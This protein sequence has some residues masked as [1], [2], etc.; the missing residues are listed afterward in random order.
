METGLGR[1]IDELEQRLRD[2]VHEDVCATL[3]E[4]HRRLSDQEKEEIRDIV[5]KFKLVWTNKGE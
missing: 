2:A 4:R 3:L 1:A 5:N